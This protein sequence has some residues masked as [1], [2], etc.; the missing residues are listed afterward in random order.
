MYTPFALALEVFIVTEH[1]ISIVM[2]TRSRTYSDD[3]I[4]EMWLQSQR[5]PHTQSC[6]RRDSAR[7]LAH[8]GKRLKDIGLGDLQAFAQHLIGEGLAPISRSR[9]L[10]AV[11]S[12]V[13]FCFRMRFI[14]VNFASELAL[15]RYENRLAER[16][17]SE[18]SVLRLLAAGD[19]QRDRILL[20]L[21][22][23]GG[24]RVSEAIN[25]RWRNLHSHGDAGQISIFGK[26][27]RTRSVS[28]PTGL[29]KE[30]M[31]LR[32]FAG[33][34][35]PVFASRSGKP[36]DRGR[37]RTLVR[38]AAESA[39]V[40]GAVSPHWLRHAHASHA[41]DNGAPLSL[42]QATLGHAS[43]S[44]TSAYLHVVSN[45]SSARFLKSPGTGHT[46]RSARRIR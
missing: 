10:A 16:V 15:P 25:L 8:V 6:Y 45:D 17:L 41:L 32:G 24:L 9:T 35:D 1:S 2:S 3:E 46:P 22:Y 19:C 36:L 27:G 42:I 26:S 43:I 28:L 34:E 23:L 44:T 30:L 18:E 5:S 12:L 38:R 20:N 21:L 13:G 33:A 4:V 31:V 37:V 11:R 7:V 39:G 29:W 14:P 40:P